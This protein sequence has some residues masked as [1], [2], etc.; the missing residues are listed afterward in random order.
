MADLDEWL[1]AADRPHM[2]RHDHESDDLTAKTNMPDHKAPISTIEGAGNLLAFNAEQLMRQYEAE[3]A[4]TRSA[5]EWRRL[6]KWHIEREEFTIIDLAHRLRDFDR[7]EYRAER[8]KWRR[9]QHRF[10]RNIYPV[11]STNC[12]VPG[13]S[14]RKDSRYCTNACRVAAR[15]AQR[16]Y[17]RTAQIYEN[18]T[19]LPVYAYRTITEDQKERNKK[20]SEFISENIENYAP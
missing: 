10:C 9:C 1:T 15:D 16:E 3:Q 7:E 13:W 11:D 18:G 5:A 17:E 14:K 2:E 8:K 19:Y 20:D 12:V 6:E 4:R